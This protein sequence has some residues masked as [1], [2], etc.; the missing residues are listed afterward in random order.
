[1]ELFVFSYISLDYL[2]SRFTHS[3]QSRIAMCSS[4]PQKWDSV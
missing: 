2:L 4:R 1:M 3:S